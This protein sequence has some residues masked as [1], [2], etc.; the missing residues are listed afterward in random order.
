M[1]VGDERG[2][3]SAHVSPHLLPILT[4]NMTTGISAGTSLARGDHYF[5]A[6]R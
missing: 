2:G 5:V 1:S 3:L 6:P 4:F